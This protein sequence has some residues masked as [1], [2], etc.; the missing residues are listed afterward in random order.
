MN[1]F[2]LALGAMLP[3]SSAYMS[4]SKNSGR[5]FNNRK[6]VEKTSGFNCNSI[7]RMN[8]HCAGHIDISQQRVPTFPQ[9]MLHFQSKDPNDMPIVKTFEST[10]QGCLK[11]T[12][13]FCGKAACIFDGLAEEHILHR[14][15]YNNPVCLTT[16]IFAESHY[17]CDLDCDYLLQKWNKADNNIGASTI[18]LIFAL[19]VLAQCEARVITFASKRGNQ[20]MQKRIHNYGFILPIPYGSFFYYQRLFLFSFLSIFRALAHKKFIHCTPCFGNSTIR[21]FSVR[22]INKSSLYDE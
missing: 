14:F 9:A 13:N 22:S 6:C 17:D 20:R 2:I 10:S 5:C 16:K 4:C 18:G 15:K 8:C 21:L 7:M 3:T 19:L 11:S 12:H 1:V